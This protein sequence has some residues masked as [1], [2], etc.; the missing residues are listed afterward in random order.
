MKQEE[1]LSKIRG[2]VWEK[3]REDLWNKISGMEKEKDFIERKILQPLLNEEI[4]EKYG[5]E[6]PTSLL[7][8]GPP[9]TGK[10]TF[11]KAI[12]GRLSWNFLEVSPSR[13]DDEIDYL[14]QLFSKLQKL[15]KTVVFMDEFEEV[16]FN[17][18]LG[19]PRRAVTN[20]LLKLLPKIN[21][22]NG[23]ILLVCATNHIRKI[24]P[25]LLRPQRF[26]YLM[27]FGPPSKKSRKAMFENFLSNLN[28]SDELDLD[29]VSEK[30]SRFTPA[31]IK[32]VCREAGYIAFEREIETGKEEPISTED[33]LRAIDMHNPTISEEELEEFKEDIKKY[34]RAD[35]CYVD[36]DFLPLA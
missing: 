9:G 12:A 29:K 27:P 26:D 13:G 4:A 30:S 32:S 1:R 6:P 17:A 36:C 18:D 35:F 19:L 11:S 14:R 28:T 24:A 20:E 22:K 25:A 7:L 3:P 2:G 15:E 31:D 5:V 8:Y 16:A 10:T 33:I 23:E 21:E 34:C